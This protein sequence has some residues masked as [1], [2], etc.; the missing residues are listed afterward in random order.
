MFHEL[1]SRS[2]L[3]SITWMLIAFVIT[4]AALYILQRNIVVAAGEA[5]LIQAIKFVFF[6]LH[7]RAWNK[8]NFGQKLKILKKK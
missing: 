3:K 2:I 6:Y 1:H 8:S 5:I 7:E 4:T